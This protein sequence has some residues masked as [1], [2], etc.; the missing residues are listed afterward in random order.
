MDGGGV[1]VGD[2]VDVTIDVEAIKKNE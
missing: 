1:V 2:D